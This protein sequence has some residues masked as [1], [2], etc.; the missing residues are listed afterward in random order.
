ME[1][2]A[3]HTIWLG[4]CFTVGTVYFS[5]YRDSARLQTRYLRTENCF[6]KD[7]LE[8]ST[9]FHISVFQ[10]ACLLAK[11]SRF[12]FI[13]LVKRGFLAGLYDLSP[14]SKDNL[15]WIVLILTAVSVSINLAWFFLEELN[16]ERVTI[17]CIRRSSLLLVTF[18]LPDLF[19]SVKMPSFWYFMIALCTA[20][21]LTFTFFAIWRTA[22]SST[23]SR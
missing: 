10:P 22:K 3:P 4:G 6:T 21:L 20:V 5:S 23:C 9:L 2:I 1:D 11:F 8:K 17:W 12:F 16:G 14:N 15:R 13:V 19:L 18:G 7:S